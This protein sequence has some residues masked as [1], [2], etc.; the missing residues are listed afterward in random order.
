MIADGTALANAGATHLV[1]PDH[2]SVDKDNGDEIFSRVLS[3]MD[4]PTLPPS[5]FTDL[6][7][8][9]LF[10]LSKLFVP[11]VLVSTG[12][13]CGVGARAISAGRLASNWNKPIH[14]ILCDVDKGCGSLLLAHR[15]TCL[16]TLPTEMATKSE[17]IY[18][19]YVTHVPPPDVIAS[20]PVTNRYMALIDLDSDN[21][22]KAGYT[23][24]AR[25]L[26]ECQSGMGLLIFHIVC[27]PKFKSDLEMLERTLTEL[28][29]NQ[30]SKTLF[31]RASCAATF[32]VDWPCPISRRNEFYC[33]SFARVNGRDLARKTFF[34]G[35]SI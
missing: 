27:V 33:W 19:S 3:N 24:A 7:L 2:T 22:G 16:G 21:T 35:V 25:R 4:D 14:E 30:L 20:V 26:I 31:G 15:G 11:D 10:A 23:V 18:N 5:T 28:G 13:Y 1:V 9:V 34:D 6:T 29:A 17:K 32:R 8:A 12:A